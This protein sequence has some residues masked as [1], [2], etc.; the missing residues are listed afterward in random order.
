MDVDR[1]FDEAERGRVTEA[2]R[3]AEGASRGQIVPAVVGKS[4]PYP[5]AH[6]RGALLGGALATGAV[7]LLDLPLTLAELPAVQLAAGLL[8]G[9]AALWAPL[10][11]LLVGQKAMEQA[12]RARAL[13]AFHEHGLHDTAEGTGVL[14]FASLFERRAVVLGDHAIHA[15][16]GDAAWDDVVQA[17][18]AGLRRGAPGQGFE[19]AVA[20]CGARLAEHFPRRPDDG[21]AVNEL[22]D[23]IIVSRS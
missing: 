8:G 18:V 3:R 15:H 10:E 20:R 6:F 4:D 5:E 1:Y 13:R 2:V 19:E 22:K 12:V 23:A 9:L 16:M 21:P 17:L 14:V 11:R 7:L